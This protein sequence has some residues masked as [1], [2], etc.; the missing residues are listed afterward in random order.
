IFPAPTCASPTHDGV[1]WD[2]I[3]VDDRRMAFQSTQAPHRKSPGMKPV[4]LIPAA[5]SGSRLQSS[6]PKVLF[7]VNGKPMVDYL[8]TLY[9]PVV[10]QFILVLHP[11]FAQDVQ[12]HCRTYALPIEY[13]LQHVPTGMLDALLI[14]QERVRRSHLTSVWITWCDQVAIHPKTVM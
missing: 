4:L 14:P 1:R 6:V 8:F 9:A 13:E 2:T 7:P 3:A 11:S 5:G 12:R 10:A